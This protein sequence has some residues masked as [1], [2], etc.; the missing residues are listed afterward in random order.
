ME[1]RGRPRGLPRHADEPHRRVAERRSRRIQ[2]REPVCVVVQLAEPAVVAAEPGGPDHRRDALA[3]EVERRPRGRVHRPATVVRLGRRRVEAGRRDV[4]VGDRLE[5]DRHLVPEG[6]ERVHVAGEPESGAVDLGQ[7]AEQVHPHPTELRDP[8]VAAVGGDE[9]RGRA[10]GGG[11]GHRLGRG[12]PPA[13]VHVPV[14]QG[15]AAVPRAVPPDPARRPPHGAPAEGEVLGDLP[16]ALAAPDDQ[17]GTFG[18]GTRVAV[19]VGVDGVQVRGQVRRHLRDQR[20]VLRAARDHQRPRLELLVRRRDPERVADSTNGGH[21]G[22]G[23]DRQSGGAGLEQR[24]RLVTRGVLVRRRHR[25]AGRS[26][27]PGC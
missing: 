21:R 13:G 14:E 24:D 2:E 15:P 1:D 7:P 9:R 6:H 10:F 8:E 20:H 25:R 4:V 12:R 22:P 27:T 5:G 3:V 17:H 26:S 23:A 18:Q 16:A 19:V 11:V